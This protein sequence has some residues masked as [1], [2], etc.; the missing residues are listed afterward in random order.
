MRPLILAGSSSLALAADVAHLLGRELVR[1]RLERFPDGEIDLIIDE[2]VRGGDVYIVQSTSPPVDGAIHEL[3][4]LVDACRLAGALRVTTLVPY[5]GYARQDRRVH[6][7]EALGGRL[8]ARML[9]AA[10]VDRL[11]T[12]DLH[13]GA[14]ESAFD[15]PVEQLTA[16]PRL[17]AALGAF[18]GKRSIV[19]APDLGAVKLAERYARALELPVAVV[20][21]ERLSGSEVR[22]QRVIGDVADREPI[23]VDDMIVTGGTIVAAIE[24]VRAAGARPTTIVAASHLLSIA[25]G[26]KRLAT[27]RDCRFFATDSVAPMQPAPFG[28]TRVPL[29]NLLSQTIYSLYCDRTVTELASHA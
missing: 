1:R 2:T 20:H 24:A 7:R 6:G 15:F 10:G 16:V 19:V 22:A 8:V 29:S 21:K 3:L 13:S 18:V 14:L 27:L 5:F 28:V 9:A 26:T 23:V 17:A 4:M 25:T 12:V 11:V